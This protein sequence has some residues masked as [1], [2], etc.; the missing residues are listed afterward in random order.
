MTH[1]KTLQIA[2]LKHVLKLFCDVVALTCCYLK[3]L[4]WLFTQKDFH[5][6]KSLSCVIKYYFVGN[7]VFVV[8]KVLGVFHQNFQVS[9]STSQICISS[10]ILYCPRKRNLHVASQTYNKQIDKYLDRQT[11]TYNNND[12]KKKKK[13]IIKI[14]TYSTFTQIQVQ[15]NSCICLICT[16]GFGVFY[17]RGAVHTM[18]TSSEL[19]YLIKNV[20]TIICICNQSL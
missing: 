8:H 12:Y 5:P 20:I 9:R 3:M 6:F 4:L 19:D 14:N 1:R 15:R 18:D 13:T 2:F 17:Q 16:Q 11:N 10:S 7:V